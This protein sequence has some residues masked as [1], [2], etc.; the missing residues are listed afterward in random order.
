MFDDFTKFC[1]CLIISLYG[2]PYFQL[3]V[4]YLA[5]VATNISIAKITT[6]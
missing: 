1:P 2:I 4:L 6:H 3:H 5:I